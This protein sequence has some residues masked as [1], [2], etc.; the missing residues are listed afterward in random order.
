MEEGKTYLSVS[1]P[2]G[3]ILQKAHEAI[4][5]KQDKVFFALF[6]NDGKTEVKHP[7]Y[8]NSQLNAAL[9]KRQKKEKAKEEQVQSNV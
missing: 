9:Y 1:V 6:P 4:R 3:V 7:D 2:V 8:K 5:D